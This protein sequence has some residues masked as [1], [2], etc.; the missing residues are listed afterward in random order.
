MEGKE[1]VVLR[2]E[3]TAALKSPLATK[4]AA[5]D[6]KS[7]LPVFA[8]SALFSVA[9]MMWLH[10][11]ADTKTSPI[12]SVQ[13]VS[14]QAQTPPPDVEIARPFETMT[15]AD[16]P[17]QRPQQV[18]VAEPKAAE[19]TQPVAIPEPALLKFKAWAAQKNADVPTENAEPPNVAPATDAPAKASAAQD[20][21][22]E[23]EALADKRWEE[24]HAQRLAAARRPVRSAPP[25][26]AQQQAQKPQQQAQQQSPQK[27]QQPQRPQQLAPTAS[28]APPVVPQASNSWRGGG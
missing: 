14:I 22:R 10:I 7:L 3:A 18:A 21:E 1:L 8:V 4:P 6:R 2:N 23:Q 17:T 28:A 27:P 12:P 9:A 26:Q 13:S 11:L 16:E 19:R 20:R 15:A 24:R 5:R 25:L